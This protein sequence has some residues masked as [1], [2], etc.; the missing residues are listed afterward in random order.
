MQTQLLTAVTRPLPPD[1]P[2]S[3]PAPGAPAPAPAPPPPAPAPGHQPADPAAA[4]T[5]AARAAGRHELRLTAQ[6]HDLRRGDARRR[7][8]DEPR[9]STPLGTAAGAAGGHHG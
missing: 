5:R 1:D 7:A 2:P 8:D 3:D 6:R 4:R 9:V